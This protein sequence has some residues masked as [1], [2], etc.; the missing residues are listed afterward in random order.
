MLTDTYAY[1]TLDQ[2]T[3]YTGY[4]G[5]TQQLAYDANG[6][7]LSMSEAGDANRSTLEELLR[8]KKSLSPLRLWLI[9][10]GRAW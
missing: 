6:M 9:Q 7:R 2:L 10:G 1:N 8:E 5:Y 4:D 3:S